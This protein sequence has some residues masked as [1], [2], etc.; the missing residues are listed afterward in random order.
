[1]E[2]D[3]A[4]WRNPL[5]SVRLRPAARSYSAIGSSDSNRRRLPEQ[6]PRP[7]EQTRI[8]ILPTTRSRRCASC[9]LLL[10]TEARPVCLPTS[11]GDLNALVEPHTAGDLGELAAMVD[12]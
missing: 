7:I 9:I 2:T 11:G 10:G 6:P 3:S 5:R 1:M 4:G 12:Y 8:L